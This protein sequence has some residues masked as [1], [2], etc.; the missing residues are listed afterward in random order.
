M[1][2]AE[3]GLGK[4]QWILPVFLVV[5]LC[6]NIGLLV[7]AFYQKPQP[8][9]S[10]IGTYCSGAEVSPNSNYLVFETDGSYTLYKQFELLEE[11]GYVAEATNVYALT[12]QDGAAHSVVYEDGSDTLYYNGFDNSIEVFS[13]ISQTPT[14]INL[15]EHG[16]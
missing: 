2:D 5:S 1:E 8:P 16:K 15:Q 6:L 14:F 7:F 13:K 10:I 11:G 9:N 12:A 4:K 3:A